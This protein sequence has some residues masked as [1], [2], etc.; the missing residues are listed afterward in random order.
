M[1]E[2]FEDYKELA[3]AIKGAGEIMYYQSKIPEQVD[4]EVNWSNPYEVMSAHA[5]IVEGQRLEVFYY[6]F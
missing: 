3:L 4:T 6:S 5:K 1:K 2:D